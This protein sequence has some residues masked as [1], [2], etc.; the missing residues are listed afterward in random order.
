[1]YRLS[2]DVFV[3]LVLE[4]LSSFPIRE[5]MLEDSRDSQHERITFVK[6]FDGFQL[7]PIHLKIILV[8][9][10]C[11]ARQLTKPKYGGK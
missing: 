7:A 11:A 9:T 8:V 5:Q 2:D 1:M 4:F 6:G 3:V 10:H